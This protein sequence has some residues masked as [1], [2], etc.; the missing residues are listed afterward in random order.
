[1]MTDEPYLPL[2]IPILIIW[3]IIGL[4]LEIRKYWKKRR[5][6]KED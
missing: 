5:R 4:I 1:M 2:V 6:Q 3:F